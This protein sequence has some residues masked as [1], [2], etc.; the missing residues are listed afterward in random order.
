VSLR[1]EKPKAAE[2]TP[3]RSG[4]KR[5]TCTSGVGVDVGGAAVAGG[6]G[7]AVGCAAGTD[8]AV[9]VAGT[10]G[11]EASVG[12]WAYASGVEV[13]NRSSNSGKLSGDEGRKKAS[14]TPATQT[15]RIRN[16]MAIP[17]IQSWAL[18][19]LGGG[20]GE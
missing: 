17:A 1:R 7:V 5:S 13:A 3:L 9:G 6:S 10:C 4:I 16:T 20:G 12:G 18:P 2:M 8:V 19:R 11:G 15:H 14:T